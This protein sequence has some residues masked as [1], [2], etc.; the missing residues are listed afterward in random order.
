MSI[1]SIKTAIKAKLDSLVTD[2]VLGGATITSMKENP[3]SS[4]VGIYPHAFLM[5]PAVESEVL[6]N[7]NIIRNYTFDIMV[8]FQAE[9]IDDTSDLEVKIESMLSKFD[10]DPTLGGTAMAG[11]L[12]VSSSP[13]PAQH[14]NGKDLIMVVLQIQAKEPVALTFA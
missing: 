3:L 10:N 7:R 6:D 9:D 11:T 8:L 5:P 2:T 12:P 14:G 1:S 4:D 13:V